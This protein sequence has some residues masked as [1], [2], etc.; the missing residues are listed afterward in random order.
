MGER[1]RKRKFL[2]EI[3]SWGWAGEC[4]LT[5]HGG[6]WMR[7]LAYRHSIIAK[8]VNTLGSAAGRVHQ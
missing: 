5:A 2:T 7:L 3:D 6:E 1:R 4:G 8:M